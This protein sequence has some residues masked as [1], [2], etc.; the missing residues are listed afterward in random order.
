MPPPC[1]LWPRSP[2]ALQRSTSLPEATVSTSACDP[3]RPPP[4][5][6][7]APGTA[8]RPH[9]PLRP[10]LR[11]LCAH[12]LC[13]VGSSSSRTSQP[14]QAAPSSCA[15]CCSAGELGCLYTGGN[16]YPTGGS[17]GCCWEDAYSPPASRCTVHPSASIPPCRHCACPPSYPAASWA[18]MET[19]LL[20]AQGAA[21][22]AVAPANGES[23]A[24]AGRPSCLAAACAPASSY[25]H[26]CLRPPPQA[27]SSPVC[28]IQ[29]LP[30]LVGSERRLRRRL[31]GL[32]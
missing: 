32:H 6:V 27:E 3:F 16:H 4:C 28:L 15:P 31:H 22:H 18:P 30:Q 8:S 10:R 25:H 1:N 17:P 2:T 20:L 7:Q 11:L 26:S 24:R 5:Y 23:I 12:T 19:A 9:R 13:P 29:V 21:C 14:C